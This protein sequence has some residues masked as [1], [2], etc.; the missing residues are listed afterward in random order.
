MLADEA[1]YYLN[2]FL[3]G[4]LA[5]VLEQPK[6]FFDPV[7]GN[8]QADLFYVLRMPAANFKLADDLITEKIK[9]EGIPADSVLHGYDDQSLF[10]VLE[11]VQQWSRVE[12]ITAKLMLLQRGYDLAQKV[13]EEHV[14]QQYLQPK[15]QA[16]HQK[17][18]LLFIYAIT[19]GALLFFNPISLLIAGFCLLWGLII[20][21]LRDNDFYGQR[22][23]FFSNFER[24]HG[25]IIAL[26]NSFKLIVFIFKSVV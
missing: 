9:E 16:N 14:T 19:L 11:D 22:Y 15:Q 25:F 23:F 17:L 4:G 13:L 6:D 21:T 12:V 24:K 1:H 8:N 20:S 10:G 26:L 2:L 3:Q 7:L 18:V 5:A